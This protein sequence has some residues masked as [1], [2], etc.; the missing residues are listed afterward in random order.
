MEDEDKKNELEGHN[1]NHAYK[2]R[3]EWQEL[4]ANS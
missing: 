1:M 3:L 2:L 4:M